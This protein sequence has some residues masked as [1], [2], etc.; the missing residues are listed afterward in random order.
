MTPTPLQSA[1]ALD[2]GRLTAAESFLRRVGTPASKTFH[3]PTMPTQP[4]GSHGYNATSLKLV[5]NTTRLNES[6]LRFV[7][8][9]SPRGDL[10]NCPPI[11]NGAA[12]KR[13]LGIDT[14]WYHKTGLL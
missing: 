3:I 10:L 6:A 14:R 8:N 2:I 7:V 13:A 11:T 4:A 1:D 12:M 5:P 9:E